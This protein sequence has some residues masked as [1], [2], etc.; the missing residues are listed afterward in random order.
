MA[1]RGGQAQQTA[2]R[3]RVWWQAPAHAVI[4]LCPCPPLFVRAA[5]VD[6]TRARARARA[7]LFVR[8][9]ALPFICALF[10]AACLS[11]LGC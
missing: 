4:C 2:L 9:C 7:R 8:A 11:A 10:I 6:C 1:G 5:T 3:L